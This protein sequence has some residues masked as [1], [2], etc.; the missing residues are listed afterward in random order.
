MEIRETS[1]NTLFLS[2]FNSGNVPGEKKK[3]NITL[4]FNLQPD[5]NVNVHQKELQ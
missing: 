5:K 4:A 1:D 2:A 3:C